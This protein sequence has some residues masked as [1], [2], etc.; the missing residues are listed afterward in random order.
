[1]KKSEGM[2]L[3]RWRYVLV[4]GS[5]QAIMAVT[6]GRMIRRSEN[7]ILIKLRPSDR[8]RILEGMTATGLEILAVSG[9]IRGSERQLIRR[10]FL[11]R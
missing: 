2:K 7:W 6:Q 11:L 1:M 3:Q 9:T 5:S 4:A 8:K 10:G